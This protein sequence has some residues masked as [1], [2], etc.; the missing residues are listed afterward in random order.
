MVETSILFVDDEMIIRKSFTRELQI[1][2]FAVTT[3]SSGSKAIKAL[4]SRQ[5]ELVITDLMMVGVDGFEV[6]KAVQKLAP[7]T[8]VIILTDDFDRGVAM[9]ALRLGADDF[10][11]KPC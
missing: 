3:V 6:L 4:E 5:Y 1:E 7:Q 10:A 8:I 2:H 9:D 11:L